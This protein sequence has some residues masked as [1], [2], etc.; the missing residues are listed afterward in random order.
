MTR[1][2]RHSTRRLVMTLI[3][4]QLVH[5]MRNILNVTQWL[6]SLDFDVTD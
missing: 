3:P 6:C 4:T 1:M 2:G 5:P